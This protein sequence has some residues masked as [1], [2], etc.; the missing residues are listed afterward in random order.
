MKRWS[1][2]H[3]RVAART[4]AQRLQPSISVV[5]VVTFVANIVMG[6]FSALLVKAISNVYASPIGGVSTWTEVLLFVGYIGV[7]AIVAC[8]IILCLV[9]A[10]T[11]GSR[12]RRLASIIASYASVT[13]T[14]ASMYVALSVQADA[15]D[16][17]DKYYYYRSY[18]D[19]LGNSGD[20]PVMRDYRALNGMPDRLWSSPDWPD[21]IGILV[22]TPRMHQTTPLSS[23]QLVA[24]GGEPLDKAVHF[25]PDEVG[26]V[27]ADALHFSVD[28]I[29]TV[30]YGDMTPGTPIAR[31][32]SDVEVCCG[33]VLLVIALQLTFAGG[34]QGGPLSENLTG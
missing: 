25:L 30:G 17:V 7:A 18:V 22:A 14:F 8:S 2:H 31:I 10:F 28:T 32:L 3:L 5:V 33:I 16:A 34:V 9:S 19:S 1:M 13:L 24:T 27:F 29:A 6:L 20:V 11:K 4:F 12:R 23:Q 15:E 21:E 26:P